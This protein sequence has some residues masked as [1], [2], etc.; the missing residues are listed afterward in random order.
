MDRGPSPLPGRRDTQQRRLRHETRPRSPYD[1]PPWVASDEVY[2]ANPHLRTALEKRQVGYVLA[3]ARDHQTT[4]RA[5]TFRADALIKKLP[6]RAW[7]QLS[8]GAKGHRF[9]DWALADPADDRPGHH[10]LLV[11]R[12][13]RCS[14]CR[15]PASFQSR[16]RRQHV[17]VRQR[18]AAGYRNLHS[19]CGSNGSRRSH[20]SSDTI[21]G[22]VPTRH[23]SQDRTT[24]LREPLS[25]GEDRFGQG[26]AGVGHVSAV[27]TANTHASCN[28]HRSCDSQRHLNRHGT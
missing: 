14:R 6:R 4:T 28:N 10:Q 20:N 23:H 27:R 18:P 2:G 9:Y 24:S 8:A 19:C 3:V 11:R 15:T 13:R 16:N 17:A 22:D 25:G 1:H 12:N 21:D 26:P 7:Q 5:G